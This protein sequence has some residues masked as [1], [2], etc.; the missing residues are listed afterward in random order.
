MSID[1]KLVEHLLCVHDKA[2]SRCAE[3]R[4]GALPKPGP[5]VYAD[6]A[7]LTVIMETPSDNMCNKGIWKRNKYRVAAQQA[8]EEAWKRA[9]QPKFI[10]PCRV[11]YMVYT[12][13]LARDPY[14]L[15]AQARKFCTDALVNI[16]CLPGDARKHLRRPDKSD[17]C[18]V[19]RKAPRV[20]IHIEQVNEEF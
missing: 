19:D 18:E 13:K 8:T 17:W 11:W 7:T 5:G 9:S 1:R 10:G 2:R 20:E 16:G 12:S 3:C 4:E 14:N 15:I 6:H